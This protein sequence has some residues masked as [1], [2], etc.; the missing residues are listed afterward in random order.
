MPQT[1]DELTI[2]LLNHSTRSDN[3]G[4]GALTVAHIAI[5]R[6]AAER[7]G[8][9]PRFI[10]VDWKDARAP[11]VTGPDIEIREADRGYL[12]S[13]AGLLSDLR[14]C[15]IVADIGAGD[16]FSDIYGSRRLNRM[17]LAKFL[18]HLAGR[19]LIVAPQTIGPFATARSRRIARWTLNRSAIVAT[20]DDLSTDCVRGLDVG[21]AVI[22]AS[23]VALALP[24]G[25]PGPRPAGARVRIGINV[26]GLLM[27]GGYTG[28]NQFGLSVDYPALID[29]LIA[30]FL[31]QRE[32][33]EVHLVAHVIGTGL[34][35]AED[36]YRASAAIADRYPGVV[37][38]PAFAS[39]SDAK[40]YIAGL[41]FFTG[42]RMHSCVAAFSAGV[43]VVPMAYSRKFA[44]L[45]GSLG[46]GHTVDCTSEPLERVIDTILT[47]FGRRAAL[48]RELSAALGLGH[49]RLTR[50]EDAVSDLIGSLARRR[51]AA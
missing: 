7:Q 3:L 22:E 36:D 44:G 28:R 15:D 41:D 37:L 16:S 51:I 8:L 47:A 27:S 43:P 29:G 40:S 17:F 32:G 46:Y 24:Y 5:L 39:P 13:P 25:R 21:R 9:R 48:Q 11:Y 14:R 50:Y 35:R 45:F 34:D 12:M 49:A 23:D 20:R 42:A 6:R 30:G 19:P 38:A 4:V 18:T 1:Q 10:V 33:C 31:A 2:G 26:S